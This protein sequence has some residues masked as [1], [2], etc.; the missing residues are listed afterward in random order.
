MINAVKRNKNRYIDFMILIIMIMIFC[1][2][3]CE[4]TRNYNTD[5]EKVS[6]DS[7]SRIATERVLKN[8]IPR[9]EEKKLSLPDTTK[10]T[11]DSVNSSR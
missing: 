10:K 7:S 8:N 5:Q 1:L 11:R 3:G 9:N 4:K 6:S 2:F